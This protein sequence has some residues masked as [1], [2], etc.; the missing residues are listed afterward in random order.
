MS[1]GTLP[2]HVLVLCSALSVTGCSTP[3]ANA[4]AGS[5]SPLASAAPVSSAPPLRDS[6]GRVLVTVGFAPS[7]PHEQTSKDLASHGFVVDQVFDRLDLATGAVPE[8]A[9]P[10]L[11]KVPGVAFV[12]LQ[13][14]FTAEGIRDPGGS[15]R[16]ASPAT[17]A[18][19]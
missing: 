4:S 13:T 14:V 3:H 6:A 15:A 1:L 2:L 16:R 17:D 12:E 9:L 19:L 11:E 5:A 10:G 7:R 8:A 18:A